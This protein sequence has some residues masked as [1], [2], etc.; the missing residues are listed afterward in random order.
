MKVKALKSAAFTLAE[1]MVS[2]GA[3]V[4]VIGGLL[5]SSISLQKTLLDNERF[6]DLRE[7]QRRVLDYLGRELR[8]ATSVVSK[9]STGVPV[10]VEGETIEVSS[11][12]PL[13]FTLPGYYKNDV[14]GS[15]DFDKPLEVVTTSDSIGYGTTDGL[16][17]PVLVWI[18]KMYV[19]EEGSV[20]FVRRE[21]N[22]SQVIVRHAENLH[23]RVKFSP[24]GRSCNVES[25]VRTPIRDHSATLWSY[26][27]VLLRNGDHELL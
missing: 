7:D 20:C 4:V 23:V 24:D 9:D 21:A 6:V 1:M 3:S 18:T 5:V 14:P 16:A 17:S 11:E 2:M 25:W 19:P 22:T 27:E 10:E 13:I 8:R 15:A 26:D 12:S